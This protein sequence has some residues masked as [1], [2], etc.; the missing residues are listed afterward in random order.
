[1]RSQI[2]TLAGCAWY[3]LASGLVSGGEWPQILGP[4]R[5]GKA[6]EERLAERWPAS[7]PPVLWERSVG[8]G[9]SGV[10]VA[11]GRVILF[12]REK[13]DELVESIDAKTGERQWKTGFPTRYENDISGDNGP[14]CVPVVHDG[15]IFVYGSQGGLRC[16][17]AHSGEKRWSRETHD[18]FKPPQSYFGAGS[19]PIVEGDKLLVNVGGRK[20]AALVAF[21]LQDGHTVWQSFDDA[22][23]YSSPTAATVAGQRHV[24]FV[25]RLNVVSVDPADGKVRFNFRFGAP[26]PTVNAATPLVLD[27]H[28]FVTANYGVGSVY[29]RLTDD[30]ADPVWENTDSLAS[31]YATGIEH[32]GHIYAID[33]GD[34][35]PAPSN[36]RCIEPQSGKVLWK[37]KCANGTLIGADNKL[38]ML[39][40]DGKLT[41]ID[42]QAEGYRELASA[43]V[44]TPVTRP[45]PALSNGLLYVRDQKKLKCLDL[46]PT[47][48][49]K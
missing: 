24:I 22:A 35:I 48:T 38:L 20:G 44:L 15:A 13:S 36:L 1:M 33:G 23:S 17:D 16:L 19:T 45:L 41:L 46:R 34:G 4:H 10:A 8:T 27:D 30:A 2:L 31:Q 12:H 6:V 49:K 5:N 26:G 28:L 47:V 37:Q 21:D 9:W 7:G 40:V 29:A 3:C 32:E 11:D 25:T 39:D 42:P 18:D 43:K 14:R